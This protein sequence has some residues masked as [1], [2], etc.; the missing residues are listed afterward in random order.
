MPVVLLAD[1]DTITLGQVRTAL[2]DLCVFDPDSPDPLTARASKVRPIRGHGESAKPVYGFWVSWADND[3]QFTYSQH[4]STEVWFD[5]PG[6]WL[7]QW[8]R[9][10]FRA[11]VP[12]RAL[13]CA[14][15]DP[16]LPLD[17]EA[18]SRYLLPVLTLSAESD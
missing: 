10:M 8:A 9:M 6:V 14:L 18:P 3:Q 5:A 4:L 17:D 13:V 11:S 1:R 7:R 15:P 12:D 16:A 2:R